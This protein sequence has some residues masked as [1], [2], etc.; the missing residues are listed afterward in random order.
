[1]NWQDDSS[2]WSR[3]GGRSGMIDTQDSTA[4]HVD[5]LNHFRIPGFCRERYVRREQDCIHAGIC[6]ELIREMADLEF[7]M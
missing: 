7:G 1:M 6:K 3:K 5:C 2:P 4:C